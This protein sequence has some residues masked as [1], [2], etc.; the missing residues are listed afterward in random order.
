ML[1]LE[2]C[3]KYTLGKN[4]SFSL[5]APKWNWEWNHRKK[6]DIPTVSL[7]MVSLLMKRK[8]VLLIHP[9]E[10]AIINPIT[11][12]LEVRFPSPHFYSFQPLNSPRKWSSILVEEP[13]HLPPCQNVTAVKIK[14]RWPQNALEQDLMTGSLFPKRRLTRDLRGWRIP[15]FFELKLNISQ[16]IKL[17]V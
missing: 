9:Y 3:K 5:I 16:F 14:R 17:T 13:T 1:G 15:I 10:G 4:F 11:D 6:T 8:T 12:V 7:A 2:L